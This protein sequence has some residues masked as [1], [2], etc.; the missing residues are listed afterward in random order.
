MAAQ[1]QWSSGYLPGTDNRRPDLP[2][3]TWIFCTEY[4][5]LEPGA[6]RV[7]CGKGM[8]IDRLSELGTIG[9]QY[10]SSKCEERI[11]PKNRYV[12]YCRNNKHW[13]AKPNIV[14]VECVTKWNQM[15][16]DDETNTFKIAPVVIV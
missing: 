2:E 4:E 5:Q 15:D 13:T 12:A 1:K 9:D 16:P 7:V 8:K 11:K 3:G 14:C 10:C 6:K